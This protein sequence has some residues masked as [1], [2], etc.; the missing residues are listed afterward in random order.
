MSFSPS[1]NYNGKLFG[2]RFVTE[3]YFQKN[4]ENYLDPYCLKNHQ[5]FEPSEL[6]LIEN[7]T[8]GQFENSNWLEIRR[9]MMTASN[10]HRICT[11]SKSLKVDPSLCPGALLRQLFR[12]RPA[13]PTL[14]ANLLW[15]KKCEE[16]AL[17][18]YKKFLLKLHLRPQVATTGFSVFNENYLVGGSLDG[19]CS[20]K[21]R[22]AS[23]C[24][25]RWLVEVKCPYT[26]KYRAAKVAGC[27]MDV[28][29]TSLNA[30]GCYPHHTNI[31]HKFKA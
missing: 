18:L 16:K 13:Y 11:R 22:K 24:P 6:E 15:G 27:R 10:F 26:T 2:K 21:C 29:M 28:V 4:P 20:Y 19:V 7:F 31:T 17:N 25:R 5:L 12:G 1:T 14:P 8:K 3:T 30:N 9:G 23:S